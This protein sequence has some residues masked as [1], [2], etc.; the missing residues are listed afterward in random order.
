MSETEQTEVTIYKEC[1]G[2]DLER[3]TSEGWELV[4]VIAKSHLEPNWKDAP[5]PRAG[6][7]DQYGN[8]NPDTISISDDDQL[9]VGPVYLLKKGRV[10]EEIETAHKT[11][12]DAEGLKRAALQIEDRAKR[13]VEQSTRAVEGMRER[14]EQ[15]S[16]ELKDAI[17]LKAKMECDMAKVRSEI[18]EEKMRSI[19]GS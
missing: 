15:K 5:H 11:M 19:V 6:K 1:K 7:K 14:V 16:Q 3:L 13:D 18:G 2:D 4:S 12:A 8:V 9:T 10:A 17:E